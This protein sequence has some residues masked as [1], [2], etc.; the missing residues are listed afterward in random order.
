MAHPIV[1]MAHA[2]GRGRPDSAECRLRGGAVLPAAGAPTARDR[3]DVARLLV[4]PVAVPRF[5]AAALVSRATTRARAGGAGGDAD[6]RIAG[7][8][9]RRKSTPGTGYPD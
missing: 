9:D 1:A 8:S 4:G 2:G 7:W 3:V 6:R 5:R